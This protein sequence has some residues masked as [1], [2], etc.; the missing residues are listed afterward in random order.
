[1]NTFFAE[2]YQILGGICK[3][4]IINGK[5]DDKKVIKK[6]VEMIDADHHSE[7]FKDFKNNIKLSFKKWKGRFE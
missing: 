2:I 1:M 6:F 4:V 5:E 3:Q 7:G